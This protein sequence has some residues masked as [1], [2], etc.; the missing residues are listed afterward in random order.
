MAPKP[1]AWGSKA[2]IR[3]KTVRFVS[4]CD[5][6]CIA[7][8]DPLTVEHLQR[9]VDV[10]V[11]TQVDT[12]CY[13][14]GLP[15]AYEYDTKVGTRWGHG[16]DRMPDINAYREKHN[17]E[18][19]LGQGIDPL[20]VVLDRGIERGLT[21][22]PDL[23]IYDCQCGIDFDPMNRDHPDW[24][25]G[26]H[27]RH[28]SSSLLY[29]AQ[30][31]EDYR[32]VSYTWQLD[33]S[34]PEVRQ[35]TI[36]V[37]EEL[38]A[39]Y[40]VQGLQL[41]FQRRPHYFR[42]DEAVENRHLLTDMVRRIRAIAR[43]AEREQGRPVELLCRV[44]ANLGDCRR[45]GM[46]VRTWV[47]EGLIDLLIP[48][49]HL[50]FTIDAPL[51]QFVELARGTPVKVLM[52]YC[53][54]LDWPRTTSV[55]H[56]PD[57]KPSFAGV[58]PRS[59]V[60][61]YVV[62]GEMWHAGARMAFAKGVDGLSIFNLNPGDYGEAWDLSFLYEIADPE[63]VARHVKLYPF[64]TGESVNRSQTL[65]REPVLYSLYIADDPAAVSKM[66]LEV[67]VEELTV[68]D[69]LEFSLDGKPLA[70]EM[71]T[72][73]DTTGGMYLPGNRPHHFLEC[74]LTPELAQPGPGELAVRVVE[75]N[76]EIASRLTVL[77]VNIKVQAK[78]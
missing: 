41:D 7:F 16:M 47:E 72:L 8:R 24:R 69:R 33:F 43:E 28:G 68:E 53:P 60:L 10:L 49:G 76:P 74:E 6:S 58:P 62:T 3:E 44:W 54:I 22:Y 71:R 20:R 67:H 52:N 75:R 13:S 38:F 32:N 66:T 42:P 31:S 65:G 9:Q 61:D 50:C 5:G 36:D 19:L 34:H 40:R 70:M 45:L 35:R 21:V 73:P 27:A 1:L 63:A 37:A 17:L 57:Q 64:I 55:S 11:D 15:G 18:S 14:V 78:A 77:G 26:E 2:D 25:I 12:L 59:L 48:T 56:R 4:T 30:V 29:G 46:D 51:E 23:R 39:L